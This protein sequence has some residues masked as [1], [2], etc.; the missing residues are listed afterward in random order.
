MKVALKYGKDQLQVFIP[1]EKITEVIEPNHTKPAKDPKILVKNSLRN[2]IEPPDIQE[3]LQQASPP[4]PSITITVEDHTRPVPN[5]LVLTP[6][7]Q[8]LTENGALR[9]NITILVAT[10]LHRGL[11]GEE[12]QELR[13]FVGEEPQIVNHDAHRQSQL[14]KIGNLT[15]DKSTAKSLAVNRHL[16]SADIII[17]TGDVGFHYLFG[18]GGGA[19][20]ILPGTADA[21]S[22]RFN[23]SLMDIPEAR[24][25]NLDNPLRKAAERAAD[26]LGIDFSVNLIL[27]EQKQVIDC[28]AGDVY[29]SFR[30]AVGKVDE[31]Y[32]IPYQ[33]KADLVIVEAGGYP[34][35]IDLYQ[36]QKAVENGLE[37][38]KPGGDL[39]L[40]AKCPDGWGSVTFRE[41]VSSVDDLQQTK[42]MIKE[43]FVI[44]GHKAY[45]YAK[46]KQQAKL[47]LISDLE[48]T[49]DLRKIFTPITVNVLEEKA[50]QA[51]SVSLLK[52]G[53]STLPVQKVN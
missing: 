40:I 6:L 10:G 9:E 34:K 49:P 36:A 33:E 5:E 46:E 21:E 38:A 30:A 27:N 15:Y 25:G 16:T 17:T 7:I 2:P 24:A 43:K 22:V 8:E 52:M 48:D 29:Q 11:N 51:S 37:L 1:D 20:S 32:K 53:S 12:H 14:Q 4:D 44:G 39:A 26:L 31:I 47:C 45:I 23:H 19:K 41:W 3:V 18:Y 13:S 42:E 35:D 28:Y 50:K